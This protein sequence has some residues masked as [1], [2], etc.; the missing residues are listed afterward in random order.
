[1][2]DIEPYFGWQNYYNAYQDAQSAF[3][4]TITA[5]SYKH[6]VYGYFIHPDWDSIGSETLYCKVIMVN[7]TLKYAI[8][9]LFG[10][11]NDTLHNDVMFLK[12]V[13]V[14]Y[15]VKHQIKYFILLGHNVFQFHG[16]ETDYYEEWFDDLEDGWIAAVNFRSFIL[17]E[18]SKYRLDFYMDF[19]GT[20]Q[21]DNWRTM[22]P[23]LFFSLISALIQR[24]LA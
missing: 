21:F 13:V 4:N 12:R 8:V 1:M 14:D 15:L 16:G 2:H 9:E 18:F 5:S 10:E 11:W 20:L 7:Y 6:S 3:F 17:D 19:G 24:R 22:K 23:D